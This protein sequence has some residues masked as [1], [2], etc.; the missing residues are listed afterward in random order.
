[1]ASLEAV[2]A[3]ASD[4]VSVRR[5]ARGAPAAGAGAP[6]GMTRPGSGASHAEPRRGQVGHADAVAR[7]VGEQ[8]DRPA[9]Q[10]ATSRFSLVGGA[11][12]HARCLVDEHPGVELVLGEGAPHVG[13][14][15]AGGDVPVDPAH[16]VL[17][18]AVADDLLG[19]ATRARAGGRLVALEQPVEAAPDDEVEGLERRGRPPCPGPSWGHA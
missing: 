4:V 15:G 6:A 8:P 10:P 9:T 7:A 16:V 2:I 3:S 14:A 13:L 5:S 11:E 1:M 17:A 18:G 12:V 19:L